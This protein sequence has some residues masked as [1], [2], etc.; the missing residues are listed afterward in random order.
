[1]TTSFLK[2]ALATAGL[3][4]A[5]A[6]GFASAHSTRGSYGYDL[7]PPGYDRTA[8]GYGYNP[9][10]GLQPNGCVKQCEFDL[11][12][13]DPPSFKHADGRCSYDR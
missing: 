7:A 6:P 5:L 9:H 3:V 2:A 13:C 8:Q 10:E 1:M 11:N 12:P 4:A